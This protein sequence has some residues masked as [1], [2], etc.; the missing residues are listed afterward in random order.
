MP[1]GP[2]ACQF[3]LLG[4]WKMK[5]IGVPIFTLPALSTTSMLTVFSPTIGLGSVTV[6]R[7]VGSRLRALMRK[8]PGWLKV[9]SPLGLNATKAMF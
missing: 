8:S 6:N 2:S 5:L 3:V 1:P 7:P 4:P 9:L